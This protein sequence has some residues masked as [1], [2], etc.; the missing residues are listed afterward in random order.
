MGKRNIMTSTPKPV[1]RS[2]RQRCKN[3]RLRRDYVLDCL[4]EDNI[5][6]LDK[7]VEKFKEETDENKVNKNKNEREKVKEN[8]NDNINREMEEKICSECLMAQLWGLEC[9]ICEEWYCSKCIEIKDKEIEIIRK[10]TKEIRGLHWKCKLCIMADEPENG[11]L[12]TEDELKNKADEK[13]KDSEGIINMNQSRQDQEDTI[14][15]ITEEAAQ[16]DERTQE[17]GMDKTEIEEVGGICEGCEKEKK[18]ETL[19]ECEYCKK[20]MCKECS[21]IGDITVEQVVEAAAKTEGL[22]WACIK[23]DQELTD[24]NFQ[25]AKDEK[26]KCLMKRI[27]DQYKY[28]RIAIESKKMVNELEATM[29]GLKKSYGKLKEDYDKRG[30]VIIEI[31]KIKEIVA[32]NRSEGEE[33]QTTQGKMNEKEEE[34]R[35]QKIQEE[36][37]DEVSVNG[38]KE[39]KKEMCEECCRRSIRENKKDESCRECRRK[40]CC[41]CDIIIEETEKDEKCN[42]C[43]KEIC[44]HCEK[45]ERKGKE[46]CM[47]CKKKKCLKCSNQILRKAMKDKCKM[48]KEERC[49]NCYK[50][51]IKKAERNENCKECEKEM[52]PECRGKDV[53]GTLKKEQEQAGIKE[54]KVKSKNEQEGK[55]KNEGDRESPQDEE[56]GRQRQPNG[57]ADKENTNRGGEN[58]REESSKRGKESGR[59][60][61]NVK[62][63]EKPE[64]G[65]E[66]IQC[67]YDLQGNCWNGKNCQYRHKD[68]RICKYFLGGRCKYGNGC[69]F[70][71]KAKEK[72]CRFDKEG[73]CKFGMNCKNRH[74]PNRGYRPSRQHKQSI[75]RGRERSYMSRDRG[76]SYHKE[77]DRA[78]GN[79]RNGYKARTEKICRFDQEGRCKF[80][81]KC[82]D[83]HIPN[84]GYRASRQNNQNIQRGRERSYMSRDRGYEHR[85]NNENQHNIQRKGYNQI[86][87]GGK[88][89]E[90]YENR[91]NY[92]RDE[93]ETNEDRQYRNEERELRNVIETLVKNN[94]ELEKEVEDRKNILR[95]FL[96]EINQKL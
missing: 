7:T 44:Y 23:C 38:C 3:V 77:E 45:D 86:Y 81:A 69:R 11:N 59:R 71:H 41:A 10:S 17:E 53:M 85:R 94:K 19:I 96:Q 87:F 56:Q 22:S 68:S 73:R 93:R 18:R 16:N 31:G 74:M 35:N 66:S 20:F 9:K 43:G 37:K 55:E 30:K 39:C 21:K 82:K 29:K 46:A 33:S 25:K 54:G 2:N 13:E 40:F 75:Q 58:E 6:K 47:Q 63:Q 14:I 72:I 52:C 91:P 57:N 26:I 49:E 84:R 34:A 50:E 42:E 90:S 15:E 95:G 32:V 67:R 88:E 36:E 62:R 28:Y 4:V 51:V 80:G 89:K 65:K 1:R 8:E 24:S 92:R 70:S 61:T 12:I 60:E 5:Q 78:Y 48:C 79:G 64:G 83:R 76:A 27:K